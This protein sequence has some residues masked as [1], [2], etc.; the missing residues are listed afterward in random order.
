MFQVP[1]APSNPSSFSKTWLP[2]TWQTVNCRVGELKPVPCAWADIHITHFD[3]K[4][5]EL[6][7]SHT[8]AHPCPIPIGIL[9]TV[10]DGKQF[11]TSPDPQLVLKPTN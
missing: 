9:L 2:S 10:T 3:N 5:L 1:L 8:N 7:I 6:K 11:F 4:K